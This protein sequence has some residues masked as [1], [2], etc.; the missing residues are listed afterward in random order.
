MDRCDLSRAYEV[1]D[2]LEKLERSKRVFNV[3]LVHFGEIPSHEEETVK[4]EK[5]QF[6]YISYR[7]KI[8]GLKF[9]WIL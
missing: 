4:E 5:N 6:R 3:E 7:L 9:S 2:Q 1:I 8:Q